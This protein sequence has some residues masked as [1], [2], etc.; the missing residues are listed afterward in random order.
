AVQKFASASWT[1]PPG[2]S[3]N[4]ATSATGT[5]FTTFSDFAVGNLTPDTTPPTV[6]VTAPTGASAQSSTSVTLS[7]T[8]SDT[9]SGVNAASRSVQRQ[10]GAPVSNACTSTVWGNDGAAT[11]TAS[12]RTDNGLSTNTSYRWQT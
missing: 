9:Q 10:S 7:W 11:T 3:T 12:P 8:E 5:G 6:T 4:T 1:S 2:G